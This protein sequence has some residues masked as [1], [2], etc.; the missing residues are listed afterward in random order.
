[1]S[2]AHRKGRLMRTLVEL[3]GAA[4]DGMAAKDAILAVKAKIDLAPEEQGAFEQ[5]G[6]E[7]F[8]KLLRFATIP[9]ARAGWMQ[10]DDGVWTAT[11]EGLAALTSSPEPEA[12]WKQALTLYIA[13]KK[14]VAVAATEEEASEEEVNEATSLEDAEDEARSEILDYIGKMPPFDFQ[15]ACATLVAA[16]GHRV[17]WISP[18]GPDGGVDF[19]AYADPIG[20]TGQRIK[21]QA[22]RQQSKQDV[23]DVGAFLSKLKGGDVGVFIALG[24]FTKAA[25]ALGRVDERR[26]VLLDGPAFVRLWIEQYARLDEGGRNLLRLR[27]IWRLVRPLE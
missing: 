5:S 24:G 25:E 26:L 21:G 19:I 20:A 15:R 3:L 13:W 6:A 12:F 22:K 27:P 4:P 14:D 17:A 11:A 8:P 2:A 7:K 1:M 10:K 23:D 9:V 16:L 18:P